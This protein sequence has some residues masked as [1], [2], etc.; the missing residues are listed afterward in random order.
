MLNALSG[1]V[2]DLHAPE[3]IARLIRHSSRAH[4]E[5]IA[6]LDADR[7]LSYRELDALSDRL[8]D[9]LTGEP[10]GVELGNLA[11]SAGA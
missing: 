2:V 9:Q 11:L 10:K 6:C 7:A 3:G 5:R 1:P 8:A 4:P